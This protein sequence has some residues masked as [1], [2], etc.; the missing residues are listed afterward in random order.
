VRCLMGSNPCVRG[1]LAEQEY[2]AQAG[3]PAQYAAHAAQTRAWWVHARWTFLELLQVAD[4]GI[5]A[6]A[7]KTII[8]QQSRCTRRGK[9]ESFDRNGWRVAAA[10]HGRALGARDGDA[11]EK[12]FQDRVRTALIQGANDGNETYRALCVQGLGQVCTWGDEEVLLAL[13]ERLSDCSDLV[14]IKASSAIA[15]LGGLATTTLP[16]TVD[17]SS[18]ASEQH[19][20]ESALWRRIEVKA[21]RRRDRAS[22]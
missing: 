6:E 5:R 8:L 19:E 13:G 1:S 11:P 17:F 14:S 2:A 21:K 7:V 4:E 10:A 3:N 15:R 9:P 22:A 18:S 16:G 20:I 12:A